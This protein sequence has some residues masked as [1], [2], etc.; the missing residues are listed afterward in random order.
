MSLTPEAG[1]KTELQK[2]DVVSKFP[3]RLNTG[4]PSLLHTPHGYL[5]SNSHPAPEFLV[6]TSAQNPA[7]CKTAKQPCDLHGD[8]KTKAVFAFILGKTH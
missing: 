7:E 6:I 2:T 5:N 4:L 3:S 1:R 8:L